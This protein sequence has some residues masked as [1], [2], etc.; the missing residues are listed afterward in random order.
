MHHGQPLVSQP[1]VS[2]VVLC[3]NTERYAGDCIRSILAIDTEIPFE[4]VAVDDHSPDGTYEVL[5]SFS[6][7]RLRVLRNERNL[8]H[9]LAL[10]RAIRETRGSYVA[11][12]DSDDRYR[13][14]FLSRTVPILETFPAVGLVYG[15][16]SVI[17]PNGEERAPA[18]DRQH[19]GRDYK[20][21]ELVEL[22]ALNFICAPTMI[23][24]REYLLS[25][26]P[27]PSH[28][29]FSDWYFTV[30]IARETEFY[31]VDAVIADY[32]VHPGNMHSHIFLDKTEERSIF[33]LLD[34]V[35]G[36]EERTAELQQ[37]KLQARRKIYGRHYLTLADKYFGAFMNAD[38][39]RCYWSALR[40]DPAYILSPGILRRFSATLVGRNTYE[41]LKGICK[42]GASKSAVLPHKAA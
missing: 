36:S 17:G 41:R 6:D 5:K 8:G 16:A 2:F 31:Y 23:V 29:A 14:D 34:R 12:I 9:A 42:G 21:C 27:I 19:G 22:L 32:R 30:S 26:L 7:P 40:R 18:S 15:N 37:R 10:E 39:R 11:R 4:I 33:W 38:A 25:H 13:P 28:L 20:G 1:L 3:Y 35:F 24:R